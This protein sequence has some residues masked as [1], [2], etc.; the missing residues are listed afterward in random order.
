MAS[1]HLL[2]APAELFTEHLRTT[3]RI[4]SGNG[5][6]EPDCLQVKPPPYPARSVLRKSTQ[7]AASQ[8]TCNPTIPPPKI[9][10]F[11]RI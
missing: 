3:L 8:S 7:Q 10:T 9:P 5:K 6:N 11:F 1:A 4:N 2:T